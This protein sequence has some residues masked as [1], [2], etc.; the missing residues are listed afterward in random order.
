MPVFV[1]LFALLANPGF[2]ADNIVIESRPGELGVTAKGVD[3]R[4]LLPQIAERGAFK[5]W[6]SAALPEQPVSVDIEMM[7]LDD[8]LSV[9]EGNFRA[10]QG[11][12]RRR[13]HRFKR[14]DAAGSARIPD[15]AG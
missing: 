4:E 2:S 12:D 6:V 14:A 5:L 8:A 1:F 9:T 3:L 13:N 7:P 11:R 10:D 15:A